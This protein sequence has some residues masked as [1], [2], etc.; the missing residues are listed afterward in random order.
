M[1]IVKKYSGLLFVLL[2]LSAC[3]IHGQGLGGNASDRQIIR[4]IAASE[5]AISISGVKPFVY[6]ARREYHDSLPPRLIIL[7]KDTELGRYRQPIKFNKGP[8]TEIIPYQSRNGGRWSTELHIG[9]DRF[10][11]YKLEEKG[12]QLIIRLLPT[13]DSEAARVT[14]NKLDGS[15][16][17]PD[18]RRTLLDR[19]PNVDQEADYVIG[20]E[21]VLEIIVWKNPELS[22]VVTVRPDGKISLPLI[23]DVKAA[24]LTVSYLQMEMT[25]RLKKYQKI[26]Q[27]S[28]IVLEINSYS[29]FVM[30]EV[31]NPGKYQLRSHV[32]LL[33]AITMAGGFTL[34][35][36]KNKIRVLRSLDEGGKQKVFKVRYKDIINGNSQKNIL[37][38]SGDTVIIP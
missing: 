1:K 13:N 22:R 5:T 32:T 31:S 37:L 38:K 15:V 30:G 28:I 9:F 21:D 16:V 34:Y 33:Q 36:S 6:L 18:G 14:Y 35:A 11:D 10:V 23:G 12:S 4:R 17:E 25:E 3:A 27:V 2:A 26:P 20:P 24:G 7:L 8:V 29:I 19:Q